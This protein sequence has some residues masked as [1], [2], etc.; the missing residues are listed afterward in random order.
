MSFFRHREIY[1]SDVR[2]WKRE[3]L[4]NRS[5][6]HRLDEFPAGYSLAGCAPALP[7]SALPAEIHSAANRVCRSRLLQRTA[8]SV[9]THCLTLGDKRR[10]ALREAIATGL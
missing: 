1:Q 4:E 6:I 7:A 5:P 3:Q 10:S 9:L 8:K 2:L